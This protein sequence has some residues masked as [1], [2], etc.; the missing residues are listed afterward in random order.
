MLKFAR[1][2]IVDV[3]LTDLDTFAVHGVLDDDIYS[4]E[5]DVAV[6][7]ADLEILDIGGKWHRWTT[8]ECPRAIQFLQGAVGFR[9]GEEGFGP[10]VHKVVG[11][12]ACRHFANLLLE[13]CHS[14]K[15]AWRIL[16]WER[17]RAETP[18]LEFEE[19]RQER[20]PD[21]GTSRAS[22]T[23]Q[24][25]DTPPPR[26]RAPAPKVRRDPSSRGMTID[27]HV[28]THPA[29][30]CSSASADALIEEA[31]RIGLDGIC[32]TDHNHVWDPAEV[33]ELKQRHG[34]LVLRGNE[35]T[36][37]QG[38]ILVFGLER[39]I[40]GII[41]LKDLRRE[42]EEADG[43]MIVAHPF[44]GFLVVGI[45]QVGLTPE[46][47]MER[48]LFRYVDAVEVLNGKV[49]ENENDFAL[50]VTEGLGLPATG[51]SDA[52]EAAEVG[53]Y[54][55]EFHDIIQDEKDLIAALK[56]GEYSPVVFQADR[57]IGVRTSEA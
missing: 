47:A 13:C 34:F 9:I 24:Q 41:D 39:D 27:L 5:L 23:P 42:V 21:S 8:P 54:A 50:R 28:H 20:A 15:E 10:K 45:D 43:F 7:I 35:I 2:K 55:T 38:D 40:Q 36:T 46:K 56:G 53:V 4:I 14:A 37:N 29:S 52:H 33:A 22:H 30:P 16:Q 19:F 12:K 44:R 26:P 3:S 18:G 51:G 25:V 6:R 17:A 57:Q 32:L 31:K 1:N 49:T 48:P 11:R